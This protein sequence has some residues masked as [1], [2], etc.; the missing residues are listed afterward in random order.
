MFDRRRHF[1]L[2]LL[3]DVPDPDYR[4]ARTPGDLQ[5]AAGKEASPAATIRPKRA[6]RLEPKT[7][8][9]P[10]AC[11][12]CNTNCEVLVL[13]DEA[14]GRILKVE[15]DPASPVTKGVLCAKGL[16]ARDLLDNPGRLRT[17]LKRVGERGQGQWKPISWDEALSLVAEKLDYYKKKLGP[18]GIAFLEGTRRGWSR[19]FSRLA[20]AF[21]AM[22]HGA[23][24]WAQCLWPRLVDNAVTF[25]AS[26]MEAAECENTHC[27]LVWGVNPPAT[28]P[29]KAADIMDARERGASVIVVDPHLSET[30][31]KADL[32]L[33][34][35]PETDVALA[36]AMMHVIIDQEL[37]DSAFVEKWT[38]GFD[39]LKEHVAKCTPEWGEKITRVPA[40]LIVKAAR[41]YATAR[42]ACISRCVAL[43][44]PH[45]SVQACR[46]VSLLAAITGN[47]GLPGGNVLVS[48]RGEI[49]Q[50]THDFIGNH[51]I[52]EELLHLR[53]GYERFPFLCGKL[54]PVPSAHMPSLWETMATGLP[55]PIKAALIF[56]SN[57]VV[58]YSNAK[59]VRE[60]LAQLEFLVVADLFLTPTGQLADLV[61]PASSWLE[62]DNVI[63]SFQCSYTHTIAQQKAAVLGEARSDVDILN[64]LAGR[65]GLGEKFW[66]DE[67]SLYDYLLGPT[68]LTFSEFKTRKRLYAPLEFQQH[69]KKGFRTPSGKIEL[70][71]SILEKHGSAPLPVYIEPFQSPLSTPELTRE[72]PLIMT[73]G[74][75]PCFR[76]TENRQNPLLRE[77][78]QES[79]VRIHPD[80]AARAGIKEGDAV[81]IESSIGRAK[82]V[83]ELTEGVPPDVIQSMPGWGGEE[84]INNLIPWG[85]FAEGMGT[86]SMHSIM[87]RVRK[88]DE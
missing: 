76:H 1:A 27:V 63:S 45:D 70:Y 39:H 23:A 46:A 47:I 61:L 82:S 79:R 17:P 48:S 74:R 86:V 35:R 67:E 84:N 21:G 22:N 44:V 16:A 78:C 77:L 11:F 73:S 54:S 59:R 32:W 71:S 85:Q 69:E 58:S 65:L 28:W 37:Y 53:R 7:R 72:F 25:G 43:D 20:Y 83:A 66:K 24:G 68:G 14:S 31:A 33:Q 6:G 36:L 81:V 19:T 34:L 4:R 49:S 5:P 9:V 80:T 15:G 88:T 60:A 51:L 38:T 10:S 57:A 2:K 64:E 40:S 18:E 26:Y 42:P 50:N 52:P 29:I 8:V 55:Y 62:R 87:C 56:G 30:A 75:R 3:G 13:V 41:V 12:S